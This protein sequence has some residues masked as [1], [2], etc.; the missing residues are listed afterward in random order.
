MGQTAL[1]IE[2][3]P[4]FATTLDLDSDSI[5][6]GYQA[7]AGM[8]G[9]GLPPIV[10]QWNEGVGDGSYFRNS[11]SQSRE[12]DIPIEITGSDRTDLLARINT[13]SQ[14]FAD[15][16]RLRIV[17]PNGVDSWTNKAHR[18]GGGTLTW[19]VDTD[20]NKFVRTTITVQTFSP[21]WEQSDTQEYQWDD[22]AIS[23]VQ[24]MTNDGSAPCYPTWIIR[25]PM[26]DVRIQNEAGDLIR[27]NDYIGDGETI[28]IDTDAGTVRDQTGRNRYGG[29]ATAPRFFQL[30]PGTQ[31]VTI[32]IDRESSEFVDRRAAGRIN[33]VLN[34]KTTATTGWA[35][36]SA[37][38]LTIDGNGHLK[39]GAWNGAHKAAKL[40]IATDMLPG[41]SAVF[42][43]RFYVTQKYLSFPGVVNG[44]VA[45][46]RT[47][48]GATQTVEI[49]LVGQ[50]VGSYVDIDVPV[51]VDE[52]G[53]FT[54]KV[55]PPGSVTYD[56]WYSIALSFLY[57][58]TEGDYFD[59]T[60]TDTATYDYQ[61]LGTANA[62]ESQ[63]TVV[64]GPL[65][66][67]RL[68]CEFN[69][70]DWMVV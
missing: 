15:T 38:A 61:W 2:Y 47:G 53:S 56:N 34:P 37:G 28:T 16:M 54:V 57:L 42:K 49:P 68:R 9:M 18:I 6:G 5:S 25:G 35:D 23:S 27:Y 21:Y 13:V 50:D 8:T 60:T 33:Y 19:G 41:T 31:D 26:Q 45:V 30:D 36:N 7:L 43:A 22:T 58:G 51:T 64:P 48:D 44:S 69:P 59:G 67:S 17:D 66:E 62:S 55:L 70:R 29:L 52:T 63:E 40:T 65:T 14:A 24:T 10:T 20:G 1:H 11:R 46:K 4:G 39:I 3:G 12:I 32:T